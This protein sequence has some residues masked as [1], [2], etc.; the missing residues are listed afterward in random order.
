MNLENKKVDLKKVMF[1]SGISLLSM[2]TLANI[3]LN[4][5]EINK[6]HTEEVCLITKIMNTIGLDGNAH[7]VRK[8]EKEYQ[9][10]GIESTVSYDDS[11]VDTST[12]YYCERIKEEK[13]L[14]TQINDNSEVKY[15]VPNGYVLKNID[16]NWYGVK[17]VKDV[18]SAVSVNQDE[19]IAPEGYTLKS[20]TVTEEYPAFVSELANGETRVLK[21]K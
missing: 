17:E 6:N 9:K 16:G 20:K 5:S 4:I 13:V 3:G 7:Q 2:T 21:L 14:A 15:V 8:M 11:Y 10:Q 1:Y 19:Y 12:E 18:T